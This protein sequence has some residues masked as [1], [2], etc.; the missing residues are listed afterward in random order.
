VLPGENN[1]WKISLPE[2]FIR[3]VTDFVT[4][5]EKLAAAD[6]EAR[7]LKTPVTEH[8]E[9]SHAEETVL[10]LAFFE[11]V[12]LRNIGYPGESQPDS[13]YPYIVGGISISSVQFDSAAAKAGIQAHDLLFGL[14]QWFVTRDPHKTAQII[15]NVQPGQPLKYYVL[16]KGEVHQGELIVPEATWEAYDAPKKYSLPPSLP[17]ANPEQA[18]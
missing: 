15:R 18:Q 16:R 17:S 9:R 7:T 10:A 5:E 4:A 12:G 3:T 6:S 8:T 14:G 1:V 11:A 2:A 13:N